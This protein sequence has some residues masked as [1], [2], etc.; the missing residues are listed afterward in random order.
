MGIF[1]FFKSSNINDAVSDRQPDDI[2][3]DVRE[4]D[5]YASGHIP[6]AVNVPLST[7]N[8]ASLPWKKDTVLLVY[9]LSGIRSS[10]AVHFLKSQGY[11]NAR[12]IGGIKSYK[13][14]LEKQEGI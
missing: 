8:K 5:E 2:L 7:L 10:R 9:C 13:G 11:G 1:D 6:G 14:K 4:T 3:V 12:S